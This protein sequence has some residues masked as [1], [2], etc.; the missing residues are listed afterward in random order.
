MMINDNTEF[1]NHNVRWRQECLGLIVTD[2]KNMPYVNIVASKNGSTYAGPGALKGALKVRAYV[3]TRGK[4]VKNE[5]H[6]VSTKFLTNVL[7][8][9]VGG[10]L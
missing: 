7:L 9:N 5:V 1:I 8:N 4:D 3:R 6:I 2:H 10:L